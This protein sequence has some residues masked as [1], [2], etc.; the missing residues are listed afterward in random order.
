[1]EIAAD[2]AVT[3]E[4][5]GRAHAAT[6]AQ[7]RSADG[8]SGLRPTEAKKRKSGRV[9]GAQSA[10]GKRQRPHLP[11]GPSSFLHTVPLTLSDTIGTVG[12]CQLFVT[13]RPPLR[14][15]SSH[16]SILPNDP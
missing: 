16:E 7:P 8:K 10:N 12:D 15:F 2:S 6:R 4:V 9:P 3:R 1:M 5:L 11:L 13:G 14:Y